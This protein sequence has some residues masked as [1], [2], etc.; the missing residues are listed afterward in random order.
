VEQDFS[1]RDIIE[2]AMKNEEKGYNF[3]TRLSARVQKQETRDVFHR[4]AQEEIEH[5]RAFEKLLNQDLTRHSGI[6]LS[7]AEKKYISAIIRADVFPELD[8]G[9]EKEYDYVTPAWAFAI[10]IE[11]EKNSIL[12]Y[13]EMYNKINLQPVRD[14]FSRL[15][16]EEKLHLVELRSHLEELE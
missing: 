1:F 15:L 5:Q 12:I 13:Q 8:A 11:A 9:M 2:L 3:Y 6:Y 10:G 14:L 16:E 4:L 7:E